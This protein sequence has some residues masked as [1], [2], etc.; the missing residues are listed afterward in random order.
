MPDFR[1][2]DNYEGPTVR[3]LCPLS[4]GVIAK[5]CELPC[6]LSGGL[7]ERT[8]TRSFAAWAE[9]AIAKATTTIAMRTNGIDP[10]G[11]FG[12]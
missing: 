3:L 6:E 9:I 7:G 10:S 11:V 5:S 2:K 8:I 4:H 1:E 12:G